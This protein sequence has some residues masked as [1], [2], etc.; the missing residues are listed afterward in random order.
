MSGNSAANGLTTNIFPQQTT[1]NVNSVYVGGSL[2]SIESTVHPAGLL[3]NDVNNTFSAGAYSDVQGGRV[4]AVTDELFGDFAIGSGDNQLF[5]NQI[6][7]WLAAGVSW[8]AF[9]P[10]SGTVPPATSIDVDVTF[11]AAGL[12]GGDYYSDIVVA[13]NDPLNSEWIVPAHLNVTGAPDISVSDTLLAFGQLF[14]GGTA[15][16]GVLGMFL[17]TPVLG[18]LRVL[19]R[20]IHR[21]LLDMDPYPEPKA[22]ER[23]VAMATHGAVGPRWLPAR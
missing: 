23:A 19:G 13:N 3:F 4:V 5:G 17:A 16:G 11:D 15:L 10:V 7:D 6:I 14:I 20:Y 22:P 18:T 21:K 8:L 2:A 1:E 9:D 12:N